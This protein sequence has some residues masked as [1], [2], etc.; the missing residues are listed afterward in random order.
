MQSAIL[1]LL[2]T[3]FFHWT[4][5]SSQVINDLEFTTIPGNTNLD[6]FLTTLDYESLY[7][8]IPLIDLYEVLYNRARISSENIRIIEYI[9]NINYGDLALSDKTL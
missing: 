1:T 4:K 2:D 8:S 5:D 7:T 3:I 9:C 6:S